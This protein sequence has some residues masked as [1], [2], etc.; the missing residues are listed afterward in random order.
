MCRYLNRLL[1][2][3]CLVFLITL[4]GCGRK[5]KYLIDPELDSIDFEVSHSIGMLNYVP[6]T[7]SRDEIEREGK[8]WS[9]CIP[10]GDRFYV[11]TLGDND[12]AHEVTEEI[13]FYLKNLMLESGVASKIIKSGSA[14]A[15]YTFKSSLDEFRV[16]DNQQKAR[17]AIWVCGG[18]IGGAKAKRTDVIATTNVSITGILY[19]N[20]KEIWRKAVSDHY[21]SIDIYPERK[22]NIEISMAEAIEECCNKLVKELSNHL[23]R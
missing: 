4:N 11:R 15:E 2:F 13:D 20:D 18:L 16:I 5:T 1:L 8:N 10:V 23:A 6:M 3:L 14:D 17:T 21:E 19:R 12:Y 22:M 9:T 7:D